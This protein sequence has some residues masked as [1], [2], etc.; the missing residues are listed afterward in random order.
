[1]VVLAIFSKPRQPL[2]DINWRWK[3]LNASYPV[4][5]KSRMASM[6]FL[7]GPFNIGVP[8]VEPAPVNGRVNDG[9][10]A[11]KIALQVVTKRKYAS[12]ASI[13]LKDIDFDRGFFTVPIRRADGLE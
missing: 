3:F 13:C 8:I 10:D 1:M 11:K 6:K 4:V 7:L 2:F 5:V 9:Q 12:F